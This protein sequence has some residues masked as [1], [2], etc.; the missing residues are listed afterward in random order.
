MTF[1]LR[2]ALT[3]I[4]LG[5]SLSAVAQ[6]GT[7]RWGWAQ[8]PFS[9]GVGQTP[10]AQTHDVARHRLYVLTRLDSAQQFGSVTVPNG[11][12]LHAFDA[13]NGHWLSAT[14]LMQLSEGELSHSNLTL[15][16]ASGDVLVTGQYN[17]TLHAG[18]QTLSSTAYDG[19]IAR[20][21]P[22]NSQWRWLKQIVAASRE[23][24]IETAVVLSGGDVVVAGSF[25][26]DSL[27][28]G[29][30]LL[31]RSMPQNYWGCTGFTARLDGASGQ[32][33]WTQPGVGRDLTLRQSFFSMNSPG[34]MHKLALDPSNGQLLMLGASD[35]TA[36]F[37]NLPSLAAGVYVA[38]LDAATGQWLRATPLPTLEG[39]NQLAIDAY[40]NTYFAG[41]IMGGGPE[42]FFLAKLNPAD[43]LQ[44][45][46]REANPFDGVYAAGPMW[47]A[48]TDL[49]LDSWG[50]V[51]ISITAEVFVFCGT[52]PGGFPVYPFT[53][54]TVY[55]YD[56]ASGT[57]KW[58]LA[59]T[60][61]FAGACQI[62]ADDLGNAYILGSYHGNGF[63]LGT[64]AIPA[65]QGYVTRLFLAEL[66]DPGTVSRV[67]STTDEQVAQAL[68]LWPN[69]AHET[70]QLSGAS[71][72]TSATLTDALGRVVRTV[73]LAPGKAQ[74][75]LR[76]LPA[77]VYS[78]R[79]GAA[80]RRLVVE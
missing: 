24:A 31:R 7:G 53:P 45:L 76:G 33:Q 18:S 17:G 11:F 6:S 14:S 78:L 50:N 25:S 62:E 70:V 9:A 44:W 20:Y 68:A 27:Q 8:A 69:P 71:L 13:T 52:T 56:A 77:G 23:S 3:A 37:G 72:G 80:V 36:T 46:T 49:A 4:A 66:S 39:I 30:T 10:V 67:L 65:T 1:T 38:R 34:D 79:S 26:G 41:T 57:R 15:D 28:V 58:R 51:F 61:A 59:S 54:A 47:E 74:I 43:Q 60:N 22:S 35:T 63:H 55:N 16:A 64:S 75:D 32:W 2:T 42:S 29:S 21:S 73:R 5:V 48:A 19:F 40:G 12:S